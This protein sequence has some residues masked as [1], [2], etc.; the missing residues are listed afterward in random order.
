MIGANCVVNVVWSRFDYSIAK[1]AEDR[2]RLF[3]IEVE[4]ELRETFNQRI[5]SSCS[6][7]CCSAIGGTRARLWLWRA[8]L[9]ETM[10]GN[11]LGNEG[12]R[13]ISER[14]TRAH[15]RANC[16]RLGISLQRQAMKNLTNNH[17][18]LIGLP[19]TGKTSFLAALWYM[20]GQ[21]SV[22][23]GLSLEKLDGE[24]QYLNQI[25]DAWSEYRPV[26]RNK[27]DSEKSVSMWLKNRETGNVDA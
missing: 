4:K 6:A 23:C 16:S 11:S 15:A 7:S 26:P 24:S 13:S 17:V 21:S 10:G 5:P 1:E 9:V 18:L 27:A 20:V 19:N 22:S 25:R 14:R 2:H 3:R 8:C 12:S